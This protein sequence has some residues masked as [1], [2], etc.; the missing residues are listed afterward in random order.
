MIYITHVHLSGGTTHQHIAS[1]KWRDPSTGTTGDWSKAA[2]VTWIRSGGVAK[3]KDPVT[4]IDVAVDVYDDT[5]PY[6]R[7]HANSR[8]TDNLLALPKY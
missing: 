1:L 2:M 6:V 7:T 5:P 8:W 4:G 3:V